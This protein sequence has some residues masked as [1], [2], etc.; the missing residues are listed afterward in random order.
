MLWNKQ[1]TEAAEIITILH[2]QNSEQEKKNLETIKY[3]HLD[4][5]EQILNLKN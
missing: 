3:L 5:Q 2:K 4:Y 1:N